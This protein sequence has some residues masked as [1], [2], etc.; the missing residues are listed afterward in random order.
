M[1]RQV[2]AYERIASRIAAEIASGRWEAG[3]R[4]PGENALAQEFRVA[5]GTIR[6]ALALL[7]TRQFVTMAHQGSGTF[8]TYDRNVLAFEDGFSHALRRHRIEATTTVLR[9]GVM[10]RDQHLARQLGVGS[11]RFIAFDRR[12]NLADGTLISLERSRIPMSG[13]TWSLAG[14]DL[15]KE[16]L[17]KALQ[18]R[19]G[20]V[21]TW[22]ELEVDAV[23]LPGE[24]DLFDGGRPPDM[25]RML[26]LTRILRQ[27]D[28][29][30]VEFVQSWLH[31]GHFTVRMDAPLGENI[32]V[33]AEAGGRHD[34]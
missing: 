15:S 3:A 30:V 9:R 28:G 32:Q 7:R 8:V 20:M 23:P 10:V 5:R 22:Q 13:E 18:D 16:S 14:V 21:A 27:H 33:R 26:R 4:L 24:P 17:V 6:Q 19:A 12:R 34:G 29:R 25:G 1:Y 31:P 2:H 11:D